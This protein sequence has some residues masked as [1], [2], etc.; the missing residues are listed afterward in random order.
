MRRRRVMRGD[1]RGRLRVQ[2]EEK[3]RERKREGGGREEEEEA[4]R[5]DDILRGFN[6]E[7][8]FFPS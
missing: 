2:D 4:N 6:C 1:Q 3:R 5:R 8:H 7:I